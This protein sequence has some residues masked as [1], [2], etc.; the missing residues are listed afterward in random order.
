MEH[1]GRSPSMHNG[2]AEFFK[3]ITEDITLLI[4]KKPQCIRREV[5]SEKSYLGKLHDGVI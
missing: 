2:G 3:T 4:K 1:G 5:N